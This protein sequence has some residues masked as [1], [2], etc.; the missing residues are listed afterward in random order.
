LSDFS[1]ATDADLERARHDPAFRQ[2]MMADNLEVLLAKL[3]KLRKAGASGPAAG[4]IREGVDLAVKLAERLQDAGGTPPG[5][6]RM[7]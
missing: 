3:N 4:Q 2:R 7:A 1:P 5:K 6:S